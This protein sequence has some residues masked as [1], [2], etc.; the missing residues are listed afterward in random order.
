[1]LNSL[2]Y[3]L[4]YHISGGRINCINQG[5]SD[6]GHEMRGNVEEKELLTDDK[7]E[8]NDE[9]DALSGSTDEEKDTSSSEDNE[10]AHGGN[11]FSQSSEVD[12]SSSRVKRRRK[13]DGHKMPTSNR[14][15][16]VIC[17]IEELLSN[18]TC[19]DE[20]DCCDLFSSYEIK[21]V[22]FEEL[23][24]YFVSRGLHKNVILSEKEMRF[25]DVVVNTENLFIVSQLMNEN[26]NMTKSILKQVQRYEDHAVP[27]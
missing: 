26:R 24:N 13:I 11:A 8:Y 18:Q 27:N 12:Y 10:T 6:D 17:S 19:Q 25:V 20:K 4:I 14:L 9:V 22:V 7:N 16:K 21:K 15:E 3:N 2:Y 23:E 5:N 1:M